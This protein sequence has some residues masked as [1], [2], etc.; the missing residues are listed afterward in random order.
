MQEHAHTTERIPFNVCHD[1]GLYMK[2]RAQINSTII[3]FNVNFILFTFN[4]ISPQ[5]QILQKDS[6]QK[7]V[8]FFQKEQGTKLM[9]METVNAHT[10]HHI[11]AIK[12][13]VVAGKQNNIR[14]LQICYTLFQFKLKGAEAVGICCLDYIN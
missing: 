10:S 8:L 3:L 7:R 9:H 6:S 13:G 1:H 12:S 5:L 11:C 2:T 14:C 4:C